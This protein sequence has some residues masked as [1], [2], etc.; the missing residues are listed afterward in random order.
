ARVASARRWNLEDAAR[1]VRYD[2]LHRAARNFGARGIVVAHTRQDAAETV[3]LQ[4]ARG[5]ARASGLSPRRGRVLRPFL[6]DTRED[7]RDELRGRGE[8]W[9]EDETNADDRHARNLTRHVIL[10]AL[11]SLHPGAAAALARFAALQAEDGQ[12]LDALAGRYQEGP[13][14]GLPRPLARRAVAQRLAGAGVPVRAADVDRILGLAAED[15]PGRVTL[16]GSVQATVRRG[17][18]TIGASPPPAEAPPVPDGLT[19]RRRKPGDRLR[20]PGGDRKLSDVLIDARVP[21]EE[22]DALTV[23]AS[24]SRVYWVATSPPITAGD[25]PAELKDRP[26]GPLEAAM[27]QALALARQAGEAGETPIGAI[28]ERDG[29]VVAGAANTCAREG[30]FTR[31]AELDALRAAARVLGRPYLTDCTLVVTLEP[32]A[33]CLGAALEARVGGIVFGAWNRKAG[34]LGG[35]AGNVP[36]VLPGGFRVVPGYMAAPSERLLKKFFGR[37]RT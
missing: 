15:R 7:L 11:E 31:H 27:L 17:R 6:D 8:R 13:L 9:L 2:F 34:A 4:L 32:C 33:M 19:A 14:N 25:A 30:D 10:P 28:V 24:G 21:R 20:L 26:S 35:S 18:L 12:V 3:L 29:V 23:L 1:R 16:P 36:P 37:L 5:T 22:R